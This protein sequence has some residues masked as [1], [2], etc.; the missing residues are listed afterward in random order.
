MVEKCKR[1]KSTT[2]QSVDSPPP[3]RR[4]RLRGDWSDTGPDARPERE[5]ARLNNLGQAR[6]QLQATIMHRMTEVLSRMLA[7]PRTRIGLNSHSNE[8]THEGDITNT[9]QLENL[10]GAAQQSNPVVHNAPST[11]PATTNSSPTPKSRRNSTA[12][13][14]GLSSHGK[15]PRN[16]SFEQKSRTL[17]SDDESD[18]DSSGSRKSNNTSPTA[19]IEQE[20]E[21]AVNDSVNDDELK[22]I[23]FDYLQMKYTGHRNARTMIKEATFWGNEYVMSGSDCGHVF[24]WNR[25]TS[26]LVMLLEADQHVVNCL[27][28]HPTLPYLAT[29]GIDYDIKLFAPVSQYDDDE[30]HCRFDKEKALD[31]SR[32]AHT[33]FVL[34]MIN[35]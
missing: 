1:S 18:D 8:I 29:S 16:M 4:L 34:F 12:G 28:P 31:V 30:D 2:Q 24:V 10:F 7:D 9:V 11:A 3:V 27:Q 14:S 25:K 22:E 5:T 17:D 6:P 35:H 32:I 13:P 21:N 23:V 33:R 19:A 20:I 26:E 15:Q